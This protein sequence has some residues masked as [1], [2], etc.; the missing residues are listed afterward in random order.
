MITALEQALEHFY[1]WERRGRGWD[2]Y[3]YPVALEPPFRP[4]F[5]YL[6][7]SIHKP[8]D[9]RQSTILSRFVEG[10]LGTRSQPEI[11]E[12]ITAAEGENEPA[13][14]P[15]L[16]STEPLAEVG[17][18]LGPVGKF[19]PRHASDLITCVT[20]IGVPVAFEIVGTASSIELQVTCDRESASLL[21]AQL[22]ANS[23]D[24]S[25]V[26]RE[27]HLGGLWDRSGHARLICEMG[28]E[29][30][31]MVPLRG[32]SGASSDP[33][34]SLFAALGNLE[35]GEFAT[36]QLLFARA[37]EPWTPSIARSV[38]TD[39][40]S[41]FFHDPAFLTQTRVKVAS[42]IYACVARLAVS[43]DSTNRVHG[44][45]SRLLSCLNVIGA[46]LGNRLIA[47]SNEDYPEDTHEGDFL[48]RRSCRSGMLLSTDELAA[49]VH[50]PLSIKVAKLTRS[51]RR[52]KSAPPGH[53]KQVILGENT[54][55]GHTRVVGQS[56]DERL[57]HTY[58]I[59]SS[60]S[61]KS[62]LLLNLI[63]QDIA[64]GRGVAVFDPH[65][66]LIDEVTARIPEDRVSDV[67]LFDPA[68]AGYPV[69]FNILNARTELE[70]QLLSS[71]LVSIFRR[72][73][74]TWGDQMTSVFGNAV[75]AFLEHPRGGTLLDLRTFLTDSAFRTRFLEEVRDQEVVYFWKNQY[76]RLHGHPETSILTRLDSFVRSR[77]IREI[78]RH[79]QSGLD[80]Q[81]AID[82]NGILLCKLSQGLIGEENAQ[83][84]GSLILAKLGQMAISRQASEVSKRNPFFVYIDEF[85]HFAGPS[86]GTLLSGVRKYGIGL[87]LAHQNM[88]QLY[89]RNREL[90]E[91]VLANAG[92]R[93]L[94][95]L[96]EG[97]ARRLTDGLSF[98][99]A[100]DVLA[101]GIGDSICRLETSEND[102]NLKTHL[103]PA[104]DRDKAIQAR[105]AV[106][107]ASRARYAVEA[108]RN[109][110][111]TTVADR[112]VEVVS[113]V[114]LQP[115]TAS[116][117]HLGPPTNHEENVRSVPGRGRAQHKYLQSMVKAVA[118]DRGF[119]VTVEQQVLDGHGF[120][121]VAIEN[122]ATRIACEVSVG[123]DLDYEVQNVLKCL[124]SGFD[125][126]LLLCSSDKKKKAASNLLAAELAEPDL[127]KVH[128][129][130]F[131]D[132]A[133]F[134][135]ALPVAETTVRGYKVKVRKAAVGKVESDARKKTIGQ[136]VV[137]SIGRLKR[138][139]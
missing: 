136:I 94:F 36:V 61:G 63:L 113:E 108:A 18:V 126:V 9:G 7:K 5:Y 128:C 99:E 89:G 125:Q 55:L 100:R 121:D 103:A 130:L 79:M 30:E 1:A 124:A 52:T 32:L 51:S 104:I 107:R 70:A 34:T 133:G 95:R 102:F 56:E 3:P 69:P 58:V 38:V 115:L 62:T 37:E 93:V 25:Y 64:A 33:L 49:L 114:A 54:H 75:N 122:E 85:H 111:S 15:Y 87:T 90:A 129:V 31:F 43:A 109:T 44:I 67:I 112:L 59:G 97:D 98:F 48:N 24:H 117:T 74:T 47:L 17:I 116:L 8:D 137:R 110:V 91:A 71:D 20:S 127:A 41:A 26:L 4:F 80:V 39:S 66:D 10:I 35:S 45:A 77:L 60:G 57:R 138:K 28:L 2:V 11:D 16:P 12:L 53:S 14:R 50:L 40:G 132:L 119:K 23:S 21:T 46:P 134:F 118:Q 106:Q 123:N 92:T 29:R 139:N 72:F 131:N 13:P 22:L 27:G 120:V 135:D 86:L 81:S 82:S 6:P 105:E 42:D 76:P 78:I 96:S 19:E 73:S 88:E 84:L 68:D 65:G 101:L 83:L